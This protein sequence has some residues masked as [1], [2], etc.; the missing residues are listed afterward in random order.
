MK[1]PDLKNLTRE[2]KEELLKLLQT[3]QVVKQ[4]RVLETF[5]PHAVQERFFKSPAKIR[6][7]FGGN[8]VGKTVSMVLEMIYAHTNRHPYRNTDNVRHS[9]LV[10]PGMDKA[11]DYWGEIEKWC[12]PSLLP[13]ANKLG[14]S[15]VKQLVWKNGSI[16]TIYSIDQDI[17]KFEGTNIDAAFFDEPPHRNQWI[18][19]FRG[20][21]NNP[22]YYIVIAATPLNASWMYEDIY[23][24][25]VN[26]TDKNIEI[27]QGAIYDNPHLSKDYIAHFESQLTEDEK[28]ARLYGEFSFLSGRVF[29]E[30]SRL[31]HVYDYQVWPSDWPV[32]VAIDPHPRKPHTALYAGVTPDD[33]LVVVDEIVIEGTVEDLAEAMRKKE[34]ENGYRV[35]CRRID[36]SGVGTDWNRDSFISQLDQWSRKNGYNVRVSPMRK[37]EKDVASS[38]QKIKLLLKDKNLRFLEN[39]VNMISDMEMYAWQDHRH[40]ETS[41]IQE[42]PKK[43]HDD[44]IDPLRYIVAS[45]PVHSPSM[46]AMPVNGGSKPYNKDADLQRPKS[47]R[48]PVW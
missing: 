19:T 8:G 33:I 42:K 20:L 41:G 30:F 24:P 11:S 39:C 1:Q 35:V 36:N 34:K 14:T 25:G 48:L 3:K 45:N 44:M 29:K 38:I 21:R 15:S 4:E 46:A 7:L 43:I 17:S 23:L 37:A 13:E 10:I 16:T 32:Y 12:P 26:K 27:I 31:T 2:Q 40:P 22:D 47:S 6:A 9:W 18:S 5:K 28:K